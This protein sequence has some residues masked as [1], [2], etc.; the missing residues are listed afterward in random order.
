MAA[1]AAADVATAAVAV[2]ARHKAPVVMAEM[3]AAVDAVANTPLAHKAHVV[4]KA[5][6]AAVKAV[7]PALPWVMHNPA[8]TKVDS[9]AAWANALPALQPA[10]NQTPCAPVSI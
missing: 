4:P 10:V 1:M 8:A 9:A 3:V 5:M 2:D 7:V 6:A